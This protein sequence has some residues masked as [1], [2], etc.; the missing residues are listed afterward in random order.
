MSFISITYSCFLL[1]V[2]GI[3]WLVQSS[4][5]AT[6][7][8]KLK[9]LV[10]LSS[11]L[12]FYASLQIQYIPL[13]VLI[14]LINFYFGQALG[15][16]TV[17]G[18]H[19]TNYHLSNEEWLLADSFWNNRRSRLLWL[20]IFLNVIFLLGFKYIPFL[21]SNLAVIINFTIAQDGANWIRDN[22]IVPLGISFFIFEGIAYLIDVYR[23]APATRNLLQFAAY[24]LFFPK[25]ISGPITRYHPFALELKTLQFP[26]LDRATEGL[27]LITSGAIKKALLA[28]HIGI[29]VDL[30]FGNI[31][32]AG[33]GDL[34]LA[35][36]AYGLQLYFDFS[37]Y[38]DIA[39]GSA[40][41]LGINLP[42]NFDFPYFSISIADFWRRWHIT[43]GDWI[44][45]YLYFPLGG[46]RKGVARTCVNLFI[47]MVIIG[48]WHGAAWGFVAWGGLHG[49]ALVLHRLTEAFCE[50][51]DGIKRWWQSWS[52][53]LV[54]WFLTQFMVF[55]AWI[56]FRI[57]NLKQASLVIQN[58]W[59]HPA[60]IQFGQKVYLTAIGMERF[61]VL[62]LLVSLAAS[63][64]GV[65][66]I[67]RGLKLQLNW[68]V[69]LL[70]VPVG[71]YVVWLFAPQSGLPY[72][73]FDF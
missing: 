72:I 29:F 49:L 14:T 24:K 12:I 38:V 63:M 40:V 11:S 15:T 47:V 3:Y 39:R 68:P 18:S 5:A 34:W 48:I 69:K 58:L 23:G 67:R 32:R 53:V 21:L 70:L 43:L 22:L 57:P 7:S 59:G 28:D 66:S 41:L 62:L 51:R 50:N 30:C 54:S 26:S 65:Y 25:L 56:F 17:S 4:T 44:R 19:A 6:G 36:F 16:N 55:T 1:A 61:W 31:E 71:L 37:G 27:W 2:L 60:D 35:I 64:A 8:P 20:G 45:N 10:L 42:E 9:L 33:S 46:S 73:Y 13:L 52:G